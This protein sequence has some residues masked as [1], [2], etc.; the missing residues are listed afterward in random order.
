MLTASWLSFHGFCLRDEVNAAQKLSTDC[1]KSQLASGKAR[2]V[3][4]F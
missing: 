1:Q 3:T 2:V 4:Q